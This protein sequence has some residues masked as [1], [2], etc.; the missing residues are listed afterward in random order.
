M[1]GGSW[2]F[3]S[4]IAPAPSRVPLREHRQLTVID[5]T[6]KPAGRSLVIVRFGVL[7]GKMRSSPDAG[8]PAGDQLPASDQLPLFAPVHV[9]AANAEP[10]R[11]ED[12]NQTASTARRRCIRAS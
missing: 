5:P 10:Q 1:N 9:R 12:N 6:L 8:T 11:T 3:R 7:E 4:V 2:S